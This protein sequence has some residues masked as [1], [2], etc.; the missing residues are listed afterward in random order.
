MSITNQIAIETAGQKAIDTL[1]LALAPVKAFSTD[2]SAKMA[3]GAT[4]VQVP[5]IGA[6]TPDTT[7]NS[8]ETT[9]NTSITKV[10]VTLNKKQFVDVDLT[11]LDEFKLSNIDYLNGLLSEAVYAVG[12]AAVQDIL[13]EV[14]A[15]NFAQTPPYAGSPASFDMDSVVDCRTAANKLG[16]SPA[17]RYLVMNSDFSSG[18]LKDSKYSDAEG[19]LGLVNPFATG[20]IPPIRGF[21]PI[22]SDVIPTNSEN[23]GAFACVPTCL[24][25]AFALVDG[26]SMEQ[27]LS[28][29]RTTTVT[30]PETGISF[31]IYE[32]VNTAS[33]TSWMSVEIRYGYE[34]LKGD[35]LLRIRSAA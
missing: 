8:Y 29:A 22:E 25:A 32:H 7:E 13:S 33:R 12:K 3:N 28:V 23:L 10:E 31:G 35:S 20:K 4:I 16:W 17:N 34:T 30:D 9:G 19:R 18:I 11:G 27:Q 14:T 2:F 21:I 15:A 6:M 1:K 26:L 24:A 5:V